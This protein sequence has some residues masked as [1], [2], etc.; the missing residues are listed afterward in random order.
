MAI[1]FSKNWTINYWIPEAATRGVL[2]KKVFLKKKKFA[3]FTGKHL[4]QSLFFNK[5]A[6]QRPATLL[7]KRLWHRCFPVNFAKFARNLFCSTH[8]VARI[9]VL[10][11]QSWQNSIIRNRASHQ[12]CSIKKGALRN[13]TEFTEKNQ[14]QSHFFNKVKTRLWYRCFPVNFGKFLRTPFLQNTSGRLPL[15]K[16]DTALSILD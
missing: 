8:P 7:K 3:K 6:G 4:Y 5:V 2:Y 15:S 12:R 9:L 14:C 10:I 11:T 16:T 1:F 13:F